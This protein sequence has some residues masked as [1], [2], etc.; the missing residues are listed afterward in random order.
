MA[1]KTVFVRQTASM[2]GKLG[3]GG[4]GATPYQPESRR[5]AGKAHVS[6]CTQPSTRA[7][8]DTPGPVQY[9]K[10]VKSKVNGA[11]ARTGTLSRSAKPE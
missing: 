1:R 8:A 2:S 11:S 3:R 6:R 4:C 7:C 5:L 9:R 10:I